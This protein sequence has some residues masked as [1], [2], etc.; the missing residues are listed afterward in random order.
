MNTAVICVGKL[1][2]TF[3][4]DACN[5]YTKR[6]SR[7]GGMEIIECPDLPEPKNPSA[8]QIDKIIAEEGEDI[9]SQIRPRDFVVA[10][11]IGGKKYDSVAFS[12][13]LA[14]WDASGSTRTVFVI[15]GSN[16][17][18]P[19]VLKRANE[20]LSFSPM[21]FPHQLARVMLLEQLYRGRKILSH[22]AYHK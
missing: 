17:L 10:L 14:D 7:F 15:G 8:A 2:E 19:Q 9:L 22:E 1:K 21:T 13:K 4:R 20:T 18:S 12:Q 16:G 3:W 11:A 6:L 5:E